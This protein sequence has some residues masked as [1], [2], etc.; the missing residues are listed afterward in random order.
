MKL[1]KVKLNLFA[2]ELVERWEIG[3]YSSNYD[4]CKQFDSSKVDSSFY[5]CNIDFLICSLNQAPIEDLSLI[6]K[7]GKP[8]IQLNAERFSIE[9]KDKK[10]S[11]SF[12]FEVQNT[13]KAKKLPKG[14]YPREDE[15]L[16]DNYLFSI[17]VDKYYVSTLEVAR[18]KKEKIPSN[19]LPSPSTNLSLEQRKQYCKSVGKQL[20]STEV[21]DAAA[22]FPNQKVKENKYFYKYPF[23]WSKKREKLHPP[24]NT[25]DCTKIYTEECKTILPFVYMGDRSV[26]WIGINYALGDY[27]EVFDSL[28]NTHNLKVSNKNLNSESKWHRN[29]KRATWS[30]ENFLNNSFV[31]ISSQEYEVMK[32]NIAFRCMR[33]L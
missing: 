21:F 17:E 32:N 20:L 3:G 12:F 19:S 15:Q 5:N 14:I 18:W 10:S 16:W 28:D 2:E 25:Q 7:D 13:C 30:G 11:K 4:S 23:P 1:D 31:G 29:G 9:L 8:Y 27:A 24:K 26:S 33:F 22:F 6:K